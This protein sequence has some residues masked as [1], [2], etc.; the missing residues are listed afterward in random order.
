VIEHV[1]S[2]ERQ[3][4]FLAE[5]LRVARMAFIGTPNRWY[6]VELHTLLP[7]LHYLPHA[8]YS[9]VYRALGF[10]FFSR[11]ENLNLL[12]R[13]EL[14]QL[15]PA[16]RRDGVRVLSHRFLGIVSNYFLVVR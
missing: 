7:L 11:Q 10:D 13:R 12:G 5:V 8:F 14:E 6:P 15:L 2:R 4:A 9:R 16:E 1:G 3:R